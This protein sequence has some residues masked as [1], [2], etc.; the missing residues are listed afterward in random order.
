MHIKISEN[1]QINNII[2]QIQH[3]YVN[4]DYDSVIDQIKTNCRKELEERGYLNDIIE[5]WLEHI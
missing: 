1:D 5:Q 3:K 4:D 2:I